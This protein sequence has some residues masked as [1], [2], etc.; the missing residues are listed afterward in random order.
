MIQII[1]G[2]VN[3][4]NKIHLTSRLFVEDDVA[5]E[6]MITLGPATRGPTVSGVQPQ[7]VMCARLQPCHSHGDVVRRWDGVFESGETIV[8]ICLV[9]QD[10][11]LGWK[12]P[13]T[14]GVPH[15]PQGTGGDAGSV[16]TLGYV[17][18]TYGGNTCDKDTFNFPTALKSKIIY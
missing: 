5:A 2:A 4:N 12:P 6:R 18:W 13:V 3:N 8:I 14:P 17:G 1:H 11:M 7:R 9:L 16:C 15:H 10:E